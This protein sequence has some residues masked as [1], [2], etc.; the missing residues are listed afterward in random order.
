MTAKIINLGQ[1]RFARQLDR[2]AAARRELEAQEGRRHALIWA[3]LLAE[4]PKPT[5]ELV[6]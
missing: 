3:A 2:F 1:V 6:T 5:L 4:R